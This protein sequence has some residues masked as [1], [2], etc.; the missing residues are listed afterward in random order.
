MDECVYRSG[1]STDGIE[2]VLHRDINR[3]GVVD[4]GC[5]VCSWSE[6]RSRGIWISPWWHSRWRWSSAS[7]EFVER[8]WVVSV[9]DFFLLVRRGDEERWDVVG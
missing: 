1:E 8:E 3:G 9:S 6:V 2:Q 7:A 4:R 5:G